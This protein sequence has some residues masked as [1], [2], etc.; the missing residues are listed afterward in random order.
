MTHQ[1]LDR[2]ISVMNANTIKYNRHFR[3]I[4]ERGF[5]DAAEESF[6]EE[7]VEEIETILRRGVNCGFSK[8][9]REILR[10]LTSLAVK[11]GASGWRAVDLERLRQEKSN[12]MA[13]LKMPKEDYMNFD[14]RNN[15]KEYLESTKSGMQVLLASAPA[16]TDAERANMDTCRAMIEEIGGLVSGEHGIGYAKRE[17]LKRQHGKTPIA[18]MQGIKR[19]FDEKNIL[20]PGKICY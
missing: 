2:L 5:S 20:N 8:G 10:D 6:F 19:A 16:Q 14:L 17:F 13:S 3:D 11:I 12:L 9:M 4:L 7:V 15:M 18:L 1:E